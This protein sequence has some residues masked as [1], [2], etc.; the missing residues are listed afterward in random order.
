M[1]FERCSEVWLTLQGTCA[2]TPHSHTLAHTHAWPHSTQSSASP[3]VCGLACV[4]TGR[5][6][7]FL[8]RT[9][10]A[11][12]APRFPS[13]PGPGQPGSSGTLG[14]A[15]PT[16]SRQASPI[17]GNHQKTAGTSEERATAP[18][19][20]AHTRAVRAGDRS[21]STPGL[22]L[23]G[24]QPGRGRSES[25]PLWAAL[26]GPPCSDLS[27]QG[28]GAADDRL[29]RAPRTLRGP[30]FL[31]LEE[32]ARGPFTGRGEQGKQTQAS[33]PEPC[34]NSTLSH[35]VHSWTAPLTARLGLR[36]KA[37]RL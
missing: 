1:L 6:A 27:S 18:A 19:C 9:H 16:L 17:C 23:L 31:Q 35:Q 37:E 4:P 15:L 5:A 10:G 28:P 7:L 36:N 8:P 30:L 13:A 34:P 12:P 32:A 26:A 11:P 29:C 2:C 24:A 3:A 14:T 22:V 33:S 20:I 21:N 25:P